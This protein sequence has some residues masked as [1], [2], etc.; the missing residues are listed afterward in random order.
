MY[1]NFEDWLKTVKKMKL[2]KYI[3]LLDSEKRELKF[4]WQRYIGLM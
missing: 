4:E 2:G 1:I 3:D